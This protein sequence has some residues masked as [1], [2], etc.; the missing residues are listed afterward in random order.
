MGLAWNPAALPGLVVPVLVVAMAW[1][2]YSARPQQA[3]NRYLASYLMMA[4]LSILFGH[5]LRFLATDAAL[6]WACYIPFLFANV[7]GSGIMLLFLGTLGVP[8]LDWLRR[9]AGR[10]AAVAVTAAG[11][12]GIALSP[13]VLANGMTWQPALSVYTANVSGPFFLSYV[14]FGLLAH[15]VAFP[16]ALH[17]AKRATSA[18]QKSKAWALA[19]AFAVHALL[20]GGYYAWVFVAF[21]DGVPSY[22]A[23]DLAINFYTLAIASTVLCGLL[24]YGMLRTQLFDFERKLQWTVKRGTLAAIFLGVFFVTTQ[25]AQNYL[26]NEY[27]W[28]YGGGVA[29]LMLFAISPL[30]RVAERVAVTAVP[31]PATAA[32]VDARKEEI[33]KAALEGALQDGAITQRERAMLQ[34]L[35]L[36][37]GIA[38]PEAKALETGVRALLARA[39]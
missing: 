36:E 8:W 16:A 34:R 31:A 26:S 33:F 4:A 28:A 18:L 15:V 25:L 11:A 5:G 21:R 14:A 38:N 37:L 17:A 30:Q 24:A 7:V 10:G 39:T 13:Q 35:Q 6:A 20:L 29:G 12:L 2:V 1:A 3:Q 19:R 27:G 9:P 23:L 32:G 22:T